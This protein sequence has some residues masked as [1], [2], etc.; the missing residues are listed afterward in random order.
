MISTATNSPHFARAQDDKRRSAR[1]QIERKFPTET[2]AQ[3]AIH[4]DIA[5]KYDRRHRRAWL[6][7]YDPK[8]KPNLILNRRMADL[9]RLYYRRYKGGPIPDDDAGRADLLIAFHHLAQYPKPQQ[10]IAEWA[11]V[12]SPWLTKPERCALADM[13][14]SLLERY[15]ASRLGNMLNLTREERQALHITTIRAAGADADVKQQYKQRKKDRQRASRR[16]AGAT[17]RPGT[18][19]STARSPNWHWRNTSTCSGRA[20]SAAS[21]CPMSGCCRSEHRLVVLKT[22]ND[23]DAFVSVLVGVPTRTLHGWMLAGEAKRREWLL[24]DAANRTRYPRKNVLETAAAQT[25][26]AVD[27]PFLI[28]NLRI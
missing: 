16:E 24:P 9:E 23:D 8:H 27:D 25:V 3:K 12:W 5:N 1:R 11:R 22:D 15:S 6:N 2:A 17:L 14:I 7:K 13:V 4:L 10:C 20:R 21:I 18:T 28:S 19:T 26:A